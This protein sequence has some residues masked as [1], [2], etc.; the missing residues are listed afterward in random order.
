[1]TDQPHDPPQ[2]YVWVLDCP[3]GKRLRADSEDG[4][5]E[6]ATAHLVAEHPDLADSYGR[7]YILFMATR[8][9]A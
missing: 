3:C 8:F 5:V 4:I 9:R 6:V 2:A 7:E 1:M